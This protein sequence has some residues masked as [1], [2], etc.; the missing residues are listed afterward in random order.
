MNYPSSTSPTPTI[1]GT[2]P[3]LSGSLPASTPFNQQNWFM[4]PHAKNPYSMQWNVG[5]QHQL[6]TGTVIN[7]NSVGSGSRRMDVG[8][9]YNVALTPGPGDPRARSLF[10]YLTPSWYDKSI[11]RASYNALK[12]SVEKRFSKGLSALLSYTWS[13]S[14]DIGCSGWYGTEG[15][16]VQDPYHVN[17]NRSVSGFDLTHL[18]NLSWVYEL[19]SGPGKL[20]IL[21]PGSSTISWATG[22]LTASSNITPECLTTSA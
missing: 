7:V 1:T 18:F 17:D 2:Q 5:I 3:F 6:G 20:C 21:A 13:K 10:P 16:S 4:D 22:K 15:C 14:M 11:G 8:T 12:A 19:P 9:Y